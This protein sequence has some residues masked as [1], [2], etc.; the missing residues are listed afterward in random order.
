MFMCLFYDMRNDSMGKQ[1]KVNH[2]KNMDSR[3]RSEKGKDYVGRKR[4]GLE[5]HFILQ[6][7]IIM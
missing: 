7:T 6:I 3:G 2:Y 4:E 5:L 1:K